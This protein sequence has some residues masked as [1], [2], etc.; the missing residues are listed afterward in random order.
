MKLTEFSLIL[1]GVLLNAVAQLLLK[2]GAN[3]IGH[4]EFHPANILPIGWKLATNPYIFGGLSCYAVSVVVWI[5]ALSRVEV[6]IAYPMLSI[7]Y[8]VNALA[9]W[10]LFG[11]A[12]SMMRV[13]G[14]GVIIVGV[15]LVARS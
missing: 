8:V 9:A 13:V 2:A 12:V 14:I 7:G 11:E 3:T 4:F 6:S 1:S 10:W 5:L 15:C